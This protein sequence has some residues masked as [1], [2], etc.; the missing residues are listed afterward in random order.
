ML[1]ENPHRRVMVPDSSNNEGLPLFRRL[2]SGR[3][4]R[5]GIVDFGN[6]VVVQAQYL[7]KDFIGMLA[8]QR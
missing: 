7:A 3:V 5:T 1:R 2:F 6:L 8:Q 4:E